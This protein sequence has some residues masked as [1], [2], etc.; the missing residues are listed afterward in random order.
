MVLAE[1]GN[2]LHGALQ[3][4]SRAPVIDDK[5]S[6][7]RFPGGSEL[8]CRS[9]MRYSRSSQLPFSSPMSM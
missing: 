3:Q 6:P 1:L 4:L 5:A 8:I 9:L 7:A 2:R